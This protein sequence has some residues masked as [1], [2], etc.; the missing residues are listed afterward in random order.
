MYSLAALVVLLVVVLLLVALKLLL[1]VAVPA[2]VL[3]LVRLALCTCC[4][5]SGPMGC[6]AVCFELRAR[7]RVARAHAGTSLSL[8]LLPPLLLLPGAFSYVYLYARLVKS[9]VSLLTRP[10]PCPCP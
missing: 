7:G 8:V 9:R 6:A 5:W 1:A 10:C 2:F 3:A 4:P